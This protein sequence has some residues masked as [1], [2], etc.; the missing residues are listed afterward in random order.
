MIGILPLLL[1]VLLFVGSGIVFSAMR[2]EDAFYQLPPMV[3]ILPAIGLAWWMRREEALEAFF[4]G[5]GQRDILLMCCVF[6]L[7]GAFGQITKDIGSVESVVNMG[8]G[9]VSPQWLAIGVF[10]V[11]AF[12]GTAIGTSMGAIIAVTP[13]VVA[14]GAHVPCDMILMMGSVV[15]GAMF[16]D[17]LSLVSDTT[18]ASVSS[19]QADGGSKFVLNAKLAFISAFVCSFFLFDT[20]PAQAFDAGG[21]YLWIMILPYVLLLCLSLCHVNVLLTLIISSLVAILIGIIFGDYSVLKGI[22]SIQLGFSSMSDILMLS[23]MIGGLSGLIGRAVIESIGEKISSWVKAAGDRRLAQFFMI[24]LGAVFDVLLANN[25]I[26]IIIAAPIV[27]Q[28]ADRY[29]VKRHVAAAWVD[30]GS[31][32]MQ[33]LI[34]YGAQILLASSLSGISPVAIALKVYYCWILAL[35]LVL[36]V[37]LFGKKN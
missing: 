30:I 19:L 24:K 16:G 4:E 20:H 6:L 1:F 18:I 35:V 36:Y 8:L 5:V 23:L 22:K 15:G 28:L 26:A 12:I 34:P 13:V 37:F 10:C 14:M 25:T 2:V 9:F 33:G 17:N 7:A 27:R 32:I 11:S 31:C 29:H 21:D 3:A